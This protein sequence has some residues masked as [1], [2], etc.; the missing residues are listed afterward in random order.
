VEIIAHN[1]FAIDA[2]PDDTT[3]ATRARIAEVV[4]GEPVAAEW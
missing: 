1:F 2:L 4:Y 3:F